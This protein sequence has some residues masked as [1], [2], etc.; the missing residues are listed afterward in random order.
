MFKIVWLS[1]KLEVLNYKFEGHPK[2]SP[3]SPHF[4]FVWT[5]LVN[6]EE[7]NIAK[8]NYAIQNKTF[9]WMLTQNTYGISS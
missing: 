9:S 7:H 5:V 2:V 6:I 8:D 3:K 4:L 1:L